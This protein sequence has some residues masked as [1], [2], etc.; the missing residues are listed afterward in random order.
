MKLR[1]KTR[2]NKAKK[3]VANAIKSIKK[4]TQKLLGKKLS[5]VLGLGV[6]ALVAYSLIF[7]SATPSDVTAMITTLDGRG[8]GSG[9]VISTSTSQSVILTNFHVCDGA[10][11]KGG[12][13]RMVSGEEHIVT[14]Y[15]A[16]LEHD[17]CMVTVAAD[18]KNSVTLASSAPKAYSEATI[19]GHP[20]LMPNVITKGHF[21]GREIIPVM[22]GVRECTEKDN[23]NPETAPFCQFFGVAPIITNY[24]S[25]IVTATIMAGSSGSAVLNGSGQLSGLV[26]AGNAEGLSYAYIV[27]YEAVKNFIDLDL[28]SIDAIK[29]RPW[30]Q[31]DAHSEDEAF[32]DAYLEIKTKCSNSSKNKTIKEFCQEVIR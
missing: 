21:G 29:V 30:E 22:T 8:G 27:P 24:E 3:T 14:G 16:A 4:T 28:K 11:R 1:L 32:E 25:Q 20:S 10:L 6:V 15:A 12:K 31:Q 2:L 26:F 5:K 19:T 18:L 17:L 13:V 7:G 9:V 23:K